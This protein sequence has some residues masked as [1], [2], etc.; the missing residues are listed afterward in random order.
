MFLIF[1]ESEPQHSYKEGSYKNK[2]S[3]F[4]GVKNWLNPVHFTSTLLGASIWSDI[5]ASD[6][7]HLRTIQN[8]TLGKQNNSNSEF[9]NYY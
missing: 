6:K 5:L 1:K 4:D 2:K 8:K 3:V 7:G 9:I